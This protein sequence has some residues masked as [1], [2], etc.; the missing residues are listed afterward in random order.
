RPPRADPGEPMS[1]A[2]IIELKKIP[3][4][5]TMDEQEIGAVR[6]IM[7]EEEFAPGQ[8]ILREGDA[9]DNFHVILEGNVEFLTQDASGQELVLDDAGP[10]GFFGE[11]SMLTG[12]PRSA[13]V[14]AVARV[15]TLVLAR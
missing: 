11:L 9:G 8:V 3:L 14:R 1:E 5:S 15:R 12:E 4:F 10:G 2:E 7:A 6:A 13:R